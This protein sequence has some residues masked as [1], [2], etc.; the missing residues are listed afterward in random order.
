MASQVPMAPVSVLQEQ[1]Q[2]PRVQPRGVF[3]AYSR[4]DLIAPPDAS[5]RIELRPGRD[6]GRGRDKRLSPG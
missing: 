1:E 4:A 5:P 6:R 3:L 2:L